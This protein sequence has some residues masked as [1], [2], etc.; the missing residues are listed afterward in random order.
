MVKQRRNYPEREAPKAFF[1]QFDEQHPCLILDRD[2]LMALKAEKLLP[3]KT[4][5]YLAFLIDK[6][7][8]KAKVVQTQA[9]CAK[10]GI[11]KQD[12]LIA[13]AQLEKKGLI[14]AGINSFMN[15]VKTPQEKRQDVINSMKEAA[16]GTKH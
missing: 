10:W 7:N 14:Q 9:F 4:Y 11:S 2:E 15:E 13:I 12:F 16:S 8:V 5:V 1:E 3:L 6:A